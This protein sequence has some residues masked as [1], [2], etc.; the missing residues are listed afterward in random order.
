M[1]LIPIVEICCSDLHSVELAK[2]Y[3]ADAIELCIDLEHGGLTP[4]LAMICK[5]REIFTGEL[6]VFFRPRNGNFNYDALEKEIILDDIRI[7]LN[8]GIDTVV[9]G[10]LTPTG[11]LDIEFQKEIINVS[12]GCTISY[13]R[14]ID[15]AREPITVIEQLIELQIDRILSSGAAP[16]ANDGIKN[17]KLWNELYGNKIQFSAAGGI[18]HTNVSNLLSKTGLHR[19]HASLRNR[20]NQPNDIM[21]LGFSECAEEEKVKQL[22]QLF[23][24]T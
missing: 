7:A 14:A 2:R 18:D 23:K 24:N 3:Q 12:M 1:P 20:K 4:S 6:A 9:A 5:A 11:D 13:H 8:Q 15:I 10:A 19:F 21:D 17:L 16:C 22:T